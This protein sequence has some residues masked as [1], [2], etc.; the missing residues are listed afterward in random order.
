MFTRILFT[1]IFFTTSNLGHAKLLDKIVAIVDDNVITQS[2]VERITKH[3]A[4]KKSVAPNIFDKENY[5]QAD[6]VSILINKFLV[7]AKLSELGYTITDD[8]V[9][10][11]IKANQERLKVD[12][13]SLLHFLEQQ[14][15][16]FDEYFETLREAIEYSYFANRIITPTISVSDQ[17][18]KNTYFKNNIKDSRLNFK[19]SLVDYSL[20]RDSF[21]KNGKFNFETVVKDYRSN[22][23]LPQ[24][25]SQ[26]KSNTLE[27][28]TEEGLTPELKNLLKETDEGA[29]T[30]AIVLNSRELHIFYI[31]KKDLV[32][33]ERFSKEKEKIKDELFEQL[34]KKESSLWLERERGK[35]Y[36]KVSL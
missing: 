10:S 1:L 3:T 34:V 33:S 23:I 15:T 8:Q 27:D 11:Q 16:S 19:Y 9:E 26:L 24:E 28:I 18:V 13:K 31:T 21:P 22:G 29:L 4:I 6:I 12:R 32:E 5:N 17:D 20:T 36:I 14:G 7:R 35:H 2:Q 25:F 30:S